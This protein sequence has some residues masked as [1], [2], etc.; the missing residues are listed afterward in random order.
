MDYNDLSDKD[1]IELVSR[2][3]KERTQKISEL[4][5]MF[6]KMEEMNEKLIRSE[7]N[8]SRFLALIR[9]EFNNPL[10]GMITM[11]KEFLNESSNESMQIVYKEMLKLNFQ[12]NN[13]M[14]AAEIEND[15]LEK[16]ISE[17]DLY[18]LLTDLKESF[19]YLYQEKNISIK[20]H[21][22][23][24]ISTLNHDREKLFVVLN[25][26]LDNALKFSPDKSE[27]DLNIMIEKEKISFLITNTGNII[28]EKEFLESFKDNNCDF[29]QEKRGLG[30]GFSIIKAYCDFLNGDF[31]IK[32][33]DQLNKIKII[34]P[35]Y[36]D[37]DD[38][39]F[40]DE[41]DSFDFGDFDDDDGKSENLF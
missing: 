1:L 12:L 13:I 19:N 28:N 27:I 33:V 35:F 40:G 8:K 18:A 31:E 24:S 29:S 17:F 41:L 4:E 37:I 30:L 22:D 21:I 34:L 36:K 20:Y 7:E 16:N 26:L 10:F 14:A 2:R 9:N 39:V 6:S 5:F 38:D 3:L 11:F 23:E 15:V 25:N 32:H